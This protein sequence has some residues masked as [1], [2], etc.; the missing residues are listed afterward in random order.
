MRGKLW[1]SLPTG[2]HGAC[3]AYNTYCASL[4]TYHMQLHDPTDTLLDTEKR[5]LRKCFSGPGNWCLPGD[6]WHLSK[7]GFPR[8]A[9]NFSTLATAAQVRTAIWKH[10]PEE[11]PAWWIRAARIQTMID[12][13]YGH[14][15]VIRYHKWFSST[16]LLTLWRATQHV[17]RI[18]GSLSR[19]WENLA[20]E[21][22][23][24]PRDPKFRAARRSYQQ[25]I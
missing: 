2:L 24:D 18:L 11:E 3:T 14:P 20:G 9:R 6:L 12:N 19:H 4:P 16:P 5:T 22:R 7:F 1:Q 23:N 25:T 21:A 15:N 8:D 13:A 17:S 10:W